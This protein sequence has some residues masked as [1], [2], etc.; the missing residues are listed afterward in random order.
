MEAVFHWLGTTEDDND[1]FIMFAIGA[2]KNGAPIRRNHA[3]MLSK[4]VAVGGRVSSNLN[5]RHS[6]NGV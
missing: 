4:P 5:I 6:V 3:G 1:K 2:A